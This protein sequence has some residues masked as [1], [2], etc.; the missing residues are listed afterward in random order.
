MHSSDSLEFFLGMN[1]V[2]YICEKAERHTV[3][4]RAADHSE[5]SLILKAAAKYL[6]VFGV[7]SL[8]QH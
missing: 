3:L 7:G 6:G 2:A 1:G 8:A 4:C 5:L